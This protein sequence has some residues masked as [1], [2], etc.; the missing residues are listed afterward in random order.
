[1]ELRIDQQFALI[2]S[3][4]YP[5]RFKV[6]IINPQLHTEIKD[7][8]LRIREDLPR[9]TSIDCTQCWADMGLRSPQAF[10]QYYV[11]K[12]MVAVQQGTRAT[13]SEGDIIGDLT[14]HI[15]LGQIALHNAINQTVDVNVD[16]VPKHRPVIEV[17]TPPVEVSLERGEIKNRFIAGRVRVNNELGEVDFYL[18][19][20]PSLEMYTVGNQVD[21]VA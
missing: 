10:T 17:E 6:D 15:N 1:M 5:N 18:K 16:L 12:A 4:I 20:K 19:V 11:D 21:L 3:H 14:R 7:P 8:R 13:V 9:I 2:G